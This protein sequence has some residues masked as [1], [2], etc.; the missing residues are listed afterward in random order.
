MRALG[1]TNQHQFVYSGAHAGWAAG[2]TRAQTTSCVVGTRQTTPCK[3]EAM[4]HNS[5]E[6]TEK[7][8][9]VVGNISIWSYID[10]THKSLFASATER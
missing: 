3:Q 10:C 6:A 1:Q 9:P 4:T 2:A 8:V 7:F 5:H